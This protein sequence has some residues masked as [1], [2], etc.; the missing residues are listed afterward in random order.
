MIQ[1]QNTALLDIDHCLEDNAVHLK[2]CAEFLNIVLDYYRN[3]DS[4]I[5]YIR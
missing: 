4:Q 5:S 2:A 3:V 1:I